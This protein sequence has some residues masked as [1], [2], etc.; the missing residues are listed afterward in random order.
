METVENTM[1]GKSSL[2]KQQFLKFLQPLSEDILS[3][4]YQ[5]RFFVLNYLKDKLQQADEKPFSRH[6]VVIGDTPLMLSVARSL[7]LYTHFIDY[8]ESYDENDKLSRANQTII[9][10]VV[11]K[12]K[13]ST[14]ETELARD[15]YLCKL[16]KYCN[17]TVFG[18]VRRNNSYIDLDINIVDD[19][20]NLH[21]DHYTITQEEV[22][23]CIGTHSEAD[24]IDIDMRKAYYTDKVYNLGVEINNLSHEDINDAARYEKALNTFQYNVLEEGNPNISLDTSGWEHN[25]LAAKSG[26]SN[27]ICSDCFEI[28]ELEIRN[29]FLQ[30]VKSASKKANISYSEA[31]KIASEYHISESQ[32]WNKNIEDLSRCEHNRW[33]VEKLILGYEPWGKEEYFKYEQLFG[34]Q[35]KDYV[36]QLKN[37][38]NKD[39]TPKHIDICSN[40][41]L[42]RIDPDNIKYDTLLMLSVRLILKRIRQNN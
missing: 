14:I 40:R 11:S 23:Q 3:A 37:P 10:I 42:R 33:V 27:I 5:A 38:K 8:K 2:E 13:V 19:L 22:I 39:T 35:R 21:K 26:I 12:E 16:I 25:L 28:R 34:Q 6:F 20:D 15:E 41:D 29:K 32:V 4:W 17:L 9:T 36:K 18:N 30:E 7:A 1:I 24:I 31:F